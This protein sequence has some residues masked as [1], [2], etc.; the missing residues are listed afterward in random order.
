METNQ[1]PIREQIDPDLA[2]AIAILGRL[3]T[4]GELAGDI[5]LM[6]KNVFASSAPI[7][8]TMKALTR[9]LAAY[10][11]DH[12]AATYVLLGIAYGNPTIDGIDLIG[13]VEEESTAR[14]LRMAFRRLGGLYGE[15]VKRGMQ[16]ASRPGEDWQYIDVNTSF[17]VERGLWFINVDLERFDGEHAQVIGDPLS[18]IRIVNHLLIAINGVGALTEDH[19]SILNDAE[20]LVRFGQETMRL[21]DGLVK[22][23]FKDVLVE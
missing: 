15:D 11:G 17:D 22:S 16:L 6:V 9:N 13:G 23:G 20:D 8:D 14:E 19:L 4:S 3:S 10:F 21:R 7:I 5:Q 18:M 2:N 1:E 12:A